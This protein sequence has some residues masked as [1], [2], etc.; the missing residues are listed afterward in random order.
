[1][2]GGIT[3]QA[4]RAAGEITG[5]VA[6]EGVVGYTNGAAGEIAGVTTGGE[7]GWGVSRRSLNCMIYWTGNRS[8]RNMHHPTT[9]MVENDERRILSRLDILILRHM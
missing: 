7:A 8:R 4:V 5:G 3:G 1:L 2:L 6:T 9:L